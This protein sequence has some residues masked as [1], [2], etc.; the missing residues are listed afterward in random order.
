MEDSELHHSP[1]HRPYSEADFD[2]YQA[3]PLLIVGDDAD[4]ALV[5]SQNKLER[6]FIKAV[7]TELEGIAQPMSIRFVKHA[8]RTRMHQRQGLNSISYLRRLNETPDY[9]AVA[10][11]SPEEVDEAYRLALVGK[12]TAYQKHI[13]RQ[14]L[15]M[16]AIELTNLTIIGE[17]RK[18]LEPAMWDEISEIIGYDVSP[19]PE[20]IKDIGEVGLRISGFDRNIHRSNHI[21][22]VRIGLKRTIATLDDGTVVKART[23]APINL[24]PSSGFDQSLVERMR[25][26][27]GGNEELAQ[28]P[29]FQNA[30]M[31]LI[32]NELP[33]GLV[34][35]RNETVYE[36]HPETRAK[37]RERQDAI[38]AQCMTPE[39]INE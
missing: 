8:V 20:A 31:W 32:R 28:L 21:G 13:T 29:E 5:K 26:T 33:S 30:V 37:I 7:G 14:A 35:A 27:P 24:S 15:G 1:L 16:D 6:R 11:A 3:A 4:K 17:F 38:E 19:R 9:E 36:Y 39:E 18:Q 23:W 34:L 12:G 10:E 22:A 2:G 25:T